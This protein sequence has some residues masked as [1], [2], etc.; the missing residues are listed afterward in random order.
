MR[1]VWGP[2]LCLVVG[3]LT[4]GRGV[5]AQTSAPPPLLR[6]TVTD[7]ARRALVGV[8]V[9]VRDTTGHPVATAQT[10]TDGTF[11]ITTLS[12]RTAYRVTARH[13]GY[14]PRTLLVHPLAAG[15]TVT[16]RF[17]LRDTTRALARVNVRSRAAPRPYIV[18]STAIAKVATQDAYGLM[19]RYPWML[20]DGLIECFPDTSQLRIGDEVDDTRET[21]HWFKPVSDSPIGETLRLFV[22]GQLR[23]E[24][25]IKNILADIPSDSIAEMHYVPC[26]D[27]ERPQLRNSLVILLKHPAPG[28]GARMVLSPQPM[29]RPPR[30]PVGTIDTT[31]HVAS[32]TLSGVVG[33]VVDSLHGAALSGA[34]IDVDGT[35]REGVSDSAGRYRIDSVPPGPHRLGLFHPLLDTLGLSI[36]TNPIDFA[37]GHVT[38][39]VLATPSPSTLWRLVCAGDTVSA[40]AAPGAIAI[41]HAV[42]AAVLGRVLDADADNPLAGA[43]V[44]LAWTE[45][46]LGKETGMH[47]TRQVRTATTDASGAFR[48][49]AIP[50]PVDGDLQATLGDGAAT[51]DIPVA[52][53]GGE[54][55]LAELRI[56]TRDTAAPR[57]TVAGSGTSP[58]QGNLPPPVT[59]PAVVTGRVV[60]TAGTPITGAVVTILGA[61]PSALSRDSGAFALAHVPAGSQTLIVRAIGYAPAEIPMALT[62]R[63]PGHVTV[64]L[65]PSPAL[66]PQVH[67]QGARL[68]AL[69]K[70]GFTERRKIG[71]GHFLSDSDLTQRATANE[72]AQ[73]FEG[74]PGVRV[75]YV[76]GNA[77]LQSTRG[78]SIQSPTGCVVYVIDEAPVVSADTGAL[79]I[80]QYVHASDIGAAEVYQPSEVPGEFA[81]GGK[82]SCV[83]VVIWTKGKLGVS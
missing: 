62:S 46:Q 74:V 19:V 82:T 14:V 38:R 50:G 22:D 18:D 54:I 1:R 10:E 44:T 17:M 63:S 28:A 43:A 3:A 65:A 8:T 48:L 13:L 25:G 32:A 33:V 78:G 40:A 7:T 56:A 55:V 23:M 6:G 9:L 39:A 57:I 35:G 64:T 45:L 41:R 2:A 5:E 58:T 70:I 42:T 83:T 51:G 71:L 24:Q 76:K 15:D 20:G 59:G 68:L 72:V 80:D 81:V 52:I 26:N 67:V 21:P 36:A 53:P 66:L 4:L 49:C 79:N 12:A 77:V 37:A 27:R 16:L 34:I 31:A 75:A 69:Q 29:T 30:V 73:L 47:R 11:R 60:T 61:T